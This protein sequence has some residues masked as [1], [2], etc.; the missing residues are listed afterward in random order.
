[1]AAVMG[2][3]TEAVAQICR[4]AALGEVVE[5]ANFNGAGQIVISGHR[6]AVERALGLVERW[7]G[8]AIRLPVS[9]PFHCSLMEPARSRLEETLASV[10]IGSLRVPVVSNVDAAVNTDPLRVKDLLLAQVVGPVRWEES[11]LA[12]ARAGAT[13][14]VE[15]GPGRTLSGL[16]R[17]ICDS[18]EVAN[19]ENSSHV[20][21]LAKK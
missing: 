20:D 10:P 11:V 1:M 14:F 18:V 15:I 8:R 3:E 19:V 2:L 12:M 7:N 17:R 16:V 21:A 13:R 4:E 9:A 5:P 6:S